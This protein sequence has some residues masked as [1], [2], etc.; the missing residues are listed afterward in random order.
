MTGTINIWRL[1]DLRAGHDNQSLGLVDAIARRHPVNDITIEV[2]G[3]W[4]G[5]RQ[6]LAAGK[7]GP[8][9]ALVIGAG[10][11][12]H[13]GLIFGARRHRARSI[14]LMNPSLPYGLFDLCIVPEHDG[15][16]AHANVL[17]SFG[18]LNRIQAS[19]RRDP[20]LALVL[21]GGPSRHLEWQQELLI[22]QIRQ[23]VSARAALTWLI[24]GSPR[25]PKRTMQALRAIENVQLMDFEDASADW[26]PEKLSR[27]S[28]IWVTE[29]SMSMAYEALTS[30]AP[31]G[32]LEVNSR[33]DD[34]AGGP[35]KNAGENRIVAAIR[36]LRNSGRIVSMKRWLSE[37][38]PSSAN[39]PLSEPDRCAQNIL[40]R[41]PDLR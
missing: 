4:H 35:C 25:T 11:S 31:T 7:S 12:T 14:V 23:L 10:H 38:S 21:L 16:R 32:L 9:P 15:V 26:L 20:E 8:P 29:D 22:A 2:R 40:E 30:G 5:I 33:H 36:T 28:I 17:H 18:A 6:V 24:A 37:Q 19:T 3:I 1:S 34:H 41:W 13:A 27:A 39:E